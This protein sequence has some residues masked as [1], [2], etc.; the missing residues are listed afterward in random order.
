MR[1]W[2]GSAWTEHR[3]AGWQPPMAPAWNGPGATSPRVDYVLP[4]NRD[5]FAVAAGYLALFSFVPNPLTSIP[6]I[7]CGWV[8]LRRMPGTGRLGR[9]R[10]WFGI[11][12]GGLS[13][14]L[15]T[16]AVTLAN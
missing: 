12:V 5:G 14:G 16:L 10:A 15:F 7:V 8:A 9:G 11:V 1:W 4:T 2:N 13:L 3:N 6:A